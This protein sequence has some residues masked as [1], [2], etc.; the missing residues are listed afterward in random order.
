M[1][2]SILKIGRCSQLGHLTTDLESITSK[3]LESLDALLERKEEA[4]TNPKKALTD[5]M[6][7]SLAELIEK[8]DKPDELL[9]VITH[10]EGVLEMFFGLLH[11]KEIREDALRVLGIVNNK[12]YFKNKTAVVN[13]FITGMADGKRNN[14]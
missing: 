13:D 6:K 2:K 8:R 4:K 3:Q 5:N 11:N 1:S 9:L 10:L 14:R 12:M 7:V